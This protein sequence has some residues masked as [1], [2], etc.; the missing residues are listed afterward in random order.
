[1]TGRVPNVTDF[2]EM[3]F[4]IKS[5]FSCWNTEPCFGISQ[6]VVRYLSP[7]AGLAAKEYQVLHANSSKPVHGSQMLALDI[8]EAK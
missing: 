8:P 6:H 5:Y 4:L 3:S 7:Q 1:M 2:W